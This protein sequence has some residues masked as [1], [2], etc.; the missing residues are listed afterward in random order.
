MDRSKNLLKFINGT[1]VGVKKRVRQYADIL[2]SKH[3]QEEPLSC[4]NCKCQDLED[5]IQ[6]QDSKK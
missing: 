6:C 4:S 5:W 2:K 3:K 1:P